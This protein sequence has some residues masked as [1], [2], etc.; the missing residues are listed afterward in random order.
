M[1]LDKDKIQESI[2]SYKLEGFT[3]LAK[4][5]CYDNKATIVVFDKDAKYKQ[6]FYYVLKGETPQALADFDTLNAEKFENPFDAYAKFQDLLNEQDSQTPPPPPPP[7]DQKIPMVLKNKKT[8]QVEVREVNANL[9][10]GDEILGEGTIVDRGKINLSSDSIF[11][12]QMFIGAESLDVVLIK[13]PRLDTNGKDGYFIIPKQPQPPQGPPPE[14][15][16]GP[17]PEGPEG[18]PPEGPEG[19]PPEGPEGPPRKVPSTKRPQGKPTDDEDEEEREI[20]G[21]IPEIENEILSDRVNILSEIS[22]IDADVVKNNFRSVNLATNFLS[23]INFKEVQQRLNTNKTAYQLAQ[24]I[25][26][27]IRNS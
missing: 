4:T 3:I 21:G 17:P 1:L 20:D 7:E 16:Q 14:G 18:P 25:A 26:Q 27:E 12:T 15:P 19:P 8:N 22:G 9:E 11:E 5:W 24:E 23:Q 2:V 6:D 10:V 13:A